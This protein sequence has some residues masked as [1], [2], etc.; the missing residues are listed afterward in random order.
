MFTPGSIDK[1]AYE[2]ADE[3][4]HNMII[5]LAKNPVLTR[6]SALGKIHNRVYLNGL[7]RPPE[8]SLQE[9]L[10]IASA[11]SQRDVERADKEIRNHLVKSRQKLIEQIHE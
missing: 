9:H 6:M 3:R 4:F 7:L 8:E 10:N 2:E 11:L 5:S 1:K